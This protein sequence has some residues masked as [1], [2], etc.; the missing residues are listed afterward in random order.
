MPPRRGA[1]DGPVK[2]QVSRRTARAAGVAAAAQADAAAGVDRLTF[3]G[4]I[5][6]RLVFGS[7]GGLRS[8]QPG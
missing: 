1:T 8:D 5:I 4:N 7:S 2:C 6:A 3:G